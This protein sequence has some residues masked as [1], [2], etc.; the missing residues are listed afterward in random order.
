MFSSV[1]PPHAG[2]LSW[3]R[4]LFVSCDNSINIHNKDIFPLGKIIKSQE[5]LPVPARHC[6]GCQGPGKQDVGCSQP[7]MSFREETNVA[8]RETCPYPH[9][10][11]KLLPRKESQTR[12]WAA[13]P[14]PVQA[15][16]GGV[17]SL[18]PAITADLLCPFPGTQALTIHLLQRLV[19]VCANLVNLWTPPQNDIFKFS[20][21]NH[22]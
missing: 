13:A 12:P 6:A 20:Y 15:L 5:H 21:Q 11:S 3:P 10:V 16:P 9:A 8:T 22:L 2:G 14:G 7:Q 17:S 4:L 18:I 1:S 19:T